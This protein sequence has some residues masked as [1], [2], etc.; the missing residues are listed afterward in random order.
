MTFRLAW[1]LVPVALIA[2]AV[3]AFTALEQPATPP[4]PAS[5]TPDATVDA[6]AEGHEH[7][8]KAKPAVASTPRHGH[9]AP[10]ADQAPTFNVPGRTAAPDVVARAYGTQALHWRHNTYPRQSRRLAQ[11][12]TSSLAAA[13]R[14][15]ARDRVGLT[16]LRRDR[17]GL[18]GRITQLEVRQAD[19]HTATGVL[20]ARERAYGRS[21]GELK[22][23]LTTH[24]RVALRAT[25]DGWRVSAWTPT[26]PNQDTR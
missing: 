13:H 1:L 4:T 17:A 6:H 12:A 23:T 8:T 18:D 20:V 25:P 7:S 2:L 14:Q 9:A 10:R 21:L 22:N 19:A 15:A 11:L 26:A 5:V 24:Y 16:E 3:A